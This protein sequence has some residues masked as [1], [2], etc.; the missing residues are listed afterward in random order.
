[1]LETALIAGGVA[2][3]TSAA[4]DF[5]LAW[6]TRIRLRRLEISLAEWEERLV[7]EVKQRAAAASVQ[8]RQGKLNALDQALVQQH[9][10]VDMSTEEPWWDQLV[11]KREHLG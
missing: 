11:K 2:V 3:I 8:A 4:V 10:G 1:M 6:Q 5:L 9:T 7:R